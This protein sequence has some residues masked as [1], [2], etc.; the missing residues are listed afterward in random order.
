MVTKKDRSLIQKITK[1]ERKLNSQNVDLG[2]AKSKSKDLSNHQKHIHEIIEN[3]KEI[4]NNHD[5][6]KPLTSYYYL[7]DKAKLFLSIAT[8][9]EIEK[10]VVI[11]KELM[12]LSNE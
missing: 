3:L 12:N 9:E 11:G 6:D 10:F 1:F 7:H 5:K 4:K 2:I 8:P